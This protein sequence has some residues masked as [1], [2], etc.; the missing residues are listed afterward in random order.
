V[1]ILFLVIPV[2]HL[3][4]MTIIWFDVPCNSCAA[5]PADENH[6]VWLVSNQCVSLIIDVSGYMI[7][8]QCSI[9]LNSIE[10]E[11]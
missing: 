1:F 4:M 7:L 2:L 11:N 5:S 3:L 8:F 6:L 9:W 10:Y